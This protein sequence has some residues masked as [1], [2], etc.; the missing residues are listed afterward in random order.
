MG[1][2]SWIALQGPACECPDDLRHRGAM[3][4]A[5]QEGDI[6]P[7]EPEIRE[8][9]GPVPPATDALDLKPGVLEKRLQSSRRE[10]PV[11]FRLPV[12]ADEERHAHD[13]QTT[14]MQQAQ[15]SSRRP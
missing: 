11:V 12:D 7:P 13:R 6:R 15:E 3:A 14:G 2:A 10:P 4:Q 5:V 1:A 8:D 9:A